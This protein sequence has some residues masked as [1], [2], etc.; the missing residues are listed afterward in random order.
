M[1]LTG[2]VKFDRE[3]NLMHPAYDVVNISGTGLRTIRYCVIWP[4]GMS[5]KPRGG[6]SGGESDGE[7]G[8]ESGGSGG[9]DKDM[10]GLF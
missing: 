2:E 7:S 8:G 4:G 9:E 5:Q 10:K 1:G 6:E 3:K